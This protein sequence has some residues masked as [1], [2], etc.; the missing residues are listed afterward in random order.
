MHEEILKS[1]SLAELA[2]SRFAITSVA[3]QYIR[4]ALTPCLQEALA[5]NV[6]RVVDAHELDLT[7][8]PGEVS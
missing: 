1:K 2:E 7:T 6:M 8:D 4:P 5:D 3:A